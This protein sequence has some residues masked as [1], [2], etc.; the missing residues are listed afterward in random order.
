M[1]A[2]HL[3]LWTLVLLLAALSFSCTKEEGNEDN[4]TYQKGL[5]ITNEGPFQTGTGTITFYDANTGI[6]TQDIFELANNRELGNVVQSM[7]LHNDY[8]YIIVNNASKIEVVDAGDF[9]SVTTI[10]GLSQPRYMQVINNK[11]AYVSD[12]AGVVQIL[13]LESNLVTGTIPAGTGPEN[14]LKAGEYVYVLNGGGFSIDSTITIINSSNDQVVKT[15]EVFNRPTGIV[16]DISGNIW[17]MCSGK[18]FNGW[19]SADDTEGHLLRVNP[20]TQEIDLDIEFDVTSLH[21]EKLVINKAGNTLFFLFDN[22]IYKYSTTLAL[23]AP[24]KVCSHANLYSLAYD[25]GNDYL[26]ATDP[27]DYQS[28]G[29]LYRYN[30]ASGAMIDSIQTGVIPGNVVVKE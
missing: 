16:Q 10:T 28:N 7:T 5:Y 18:G 1:N 4:S 19:P 8:A 26:M 3:S 22:G 25:P 24:E 13:N 27:V 9:T 30:A 14:M 21:P 20:V 6:V 2:K 23:S 17:V 15:L 12:W 11:K 29:W